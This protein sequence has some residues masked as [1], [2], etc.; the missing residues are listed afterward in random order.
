MTSVIRG[1]F[2]AAPTGP[3]RLLPSELKGLRDFPAEHSENHCA[4]AGRSTSKCSL[5]LETKACRKQGSQIA[6]T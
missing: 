5:A 6:R 3:V 4:R 1:W 2:G